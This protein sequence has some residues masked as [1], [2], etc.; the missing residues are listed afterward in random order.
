[1]PP[2]F[3]G[4]SSRRCGLHGAGWHGGVEPGLERRPMAMQGKSPWP[5]RQSVPA[6]VVAVV[7]GDG[8]MVHATPVGCT[9]GRAPSGV[10]TRRCKRLRGH[11]RNAAFEGALDERLARSFLCFSG[12]L[13]G[14]RWAGRRRVVDVTVPWRLGWVG[15]E[16]S[17]QS[18]YSGRSSWSRRPAV[19]PARVSGTSATVTS[20]WSVWR[21]SQRS[22]CHFS[23]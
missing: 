7:E 10:G 18:V 23:P 3:A 13:P 1:M 4:R 6:P 17:R 19:S 5:L 22:A 2:S 11:L 16:A 8:N 14:P 15:T 9:R 20:N 21:C 12:C